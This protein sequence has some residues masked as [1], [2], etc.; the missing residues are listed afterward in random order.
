MRVLFVTSADG[1]DQDVARY[2]HQLASRL[3]GRGH[4]VEILQAGEQ[5][6][7]VDDGGGVVVH[8]LA[9]VADLSPALA[10][11]LQRRVV[12][13]RRPV[14]LYLQREWLR[15]RTANVPGLETWLEERGGGY[16]VA[17]FFGYQSR[18]TAAGLPVAASQTATILHPF[19]HDDTSLNLPVFATTFRLPDA[20]AFTTAS[21]AAAVTRRV[22]SAA[23]TAVVGLGIDVRD[24]P[25]PTGPALAAIGG[26]GA[27]AGRTA[28]DAL[29]AASGVA[30][31]YGLGPA[32]PALAAVQ[33]TY[34]AT[35][36]LPLLEAF[37]AGRVVL[38]HDR[39][40]PLARD[41]VATGGG[42]PYGGYAE[43]REAVALL[44]DEP[45]VAAAL[46]AKGRAFVSQ[47]CAWPA[48]IDRYERL[49]KRVRR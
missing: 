4:E 19:A 8:E 45:G 32:D 12:D 46:G 49:L 26:F 13:G 47:E 2:S 3:A 27:E 30:V 21:E 42:L 22:R 36:S 31:E 1:V 29:A 40:Q 35:H 20:L 14:P 18:T 23:Q 11:P 16:Q 24:T 33:H 34:F 15:A 39:G 43:F 38:V 5:S 6:Q 37:A 10:G 41:V 48:V 25:A 28:L 44:R 9:S 17:V 7:T